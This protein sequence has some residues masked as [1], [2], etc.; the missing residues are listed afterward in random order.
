MK[1][2]PELL[3]DY[4]LV[5]VNTN[6]LLSAALSPGGAPALLLDHLLQTTRLV[7]SEATY[8]ELES[9]IWKPKFDRYLSL[10]IR[11]RLL[12]EVSAAAVWVEVSAQISARAYSRDPQDDAF[13][14]AAMAAG[15]TRL[16]TGD[17]DLLILHPLEGLH[18]LTP[19][20]ALTELL[21]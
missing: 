18:I 4:A 12:R 6:V 16:I 15:A 3:A 11:R 7:Y 19:R 1:A 8:A 21:A 17:E 20:A 13:I 5:V 10:E 2:K 14:H 9:R